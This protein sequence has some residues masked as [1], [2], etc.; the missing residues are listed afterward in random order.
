MEAQELFHIRAM[1]SY[2][3]DIFLSTNQEDQPIK[4]RSSFE[5]LENNL[6][7]LSEVSRKMD[8][9]SNSKTNQQMGKR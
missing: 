8:G 4:H 7:N 6:I 1:P 9:T 2:Q 5:N 3:F